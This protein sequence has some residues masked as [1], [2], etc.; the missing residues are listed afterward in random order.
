VEL[1][2]RIRSVVVLQIISLLYPV[3][4]HWW[5]SIL[6]SICDMQTWHSNFKVNYPIEYH[7]ITR[8]IFSVFVYEFLWTND[9]IP[10]PWPWAP[11]S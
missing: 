3:T 7:C 6:Y 9:C 10:K 4:S 5:V 2:P 1:I 8:K 11:F